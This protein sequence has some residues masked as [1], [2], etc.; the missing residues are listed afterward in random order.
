MTYPTPAKQAE[1]HFNTAR[2][3]KHN[4]R[5]GKKDT[6]GR[7]SAAYPVHPSVHPA[8]AHPNGHHLAMQH[9]PASPRRRVA[10]PR[11]PSPSYD[12]YYG[13]HGRGVRDGRGYNEYYD[14]HGRP[15][16]RYDYRN[17]PRH[18][19][20]EPHHM[21]GK[22]R[23]VSDAGLPPHHPIQAPLHPATTAGEHSDNNSLRAV[24]SS[25]SANDS[26]NHAI[27]Q[28][29]GIG[30]KESPGV[31]TAVDSLEAS[32]KTSDIPNPPSLSSKSTPTNA[33]QSALPANSPQSDNSWRQL[34]QIASI[35]TKDVLHESQSEEMAGVKPN[36]EVVVPTPRNKSPN[37][38]HGL[39]KSIS[40]TSSLSNSPTEE[41]LDKFPNDNIPVSN[42]EEMYERRE[43]YPPRE[44]AGLKQPPHPVSMQYA[45]QPP[46]IDENSPSASTISTKDTHGRG[47]F[48]MKPKHPVHLKSGREMASDEAD[49]KRRKVENPSKDEDSPAN[50]SDFGDIGAMPSWDRNWSVCS[51][52][53]GMDSFIQKDLAG[54][55]VLSAFSFSSEMSKKKNDSA[56]AVEQHH[57][58]GSPKSAK[59]K[60]KQGH[61]QFSQSFDGQPHPSASRKRMHGTMPPP[62]RYNRRPPEEYSPYPPS[63]HSA[64]MPP[65]PSH[66][67][68]YSPATRYRY[69][70]R[71]YEE[72]PYYDY[73]YPP[74]YYDYRGYRPPP[75]YAYRPP[76]E[77][78]YPPTQPRASSSA[79]R[80]PVPVH[81][82]AP[83]PRPAI[84]GSWEKDDDLALMEIMKKQKN[85]KNWDP[86]AQKLGR[87]K[88]GKECYDRWTRF[89]K[90]GSRKGQWTE[91]EDRIVF[92]AV[93]N[94]SEDPFTR[95]SDLAQ[96]LPG[97]VG[98]QVRD[99][100]VNHLN[101]NINHLPFSKEDDLKL[102]EG[103]CA[104]GKRWVEISAKHFNNTRS[105]NHI[106]NRWYS[107][108]F[109]KFI[110]AE[111]G[112]DAYRIGNEQGG[113]GVDLP[114]FV[115]GKVN[116][117][118]EST[119]DEAKKS[120]SSSGR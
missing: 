51:G 82:A 26:L 39:E 33:L 78:D 31:V 80:Q 117:S 113:T 28:N 86:I 94:S 30:V 49:P 37:D 77:Y 58:D 36:E 110:T 111:F 23:S 91:A 10:M 108:S 55:G 52:M 4:N 87:G 57:E 67:Y 7:P 70:P 66:G 29:G 32:N 48:G 19:Y 84:T 43:G 3:P 92:E 18:Y 27:Q 119:S 14:H 89:L 6:E 2:T 24:S 102:W 106:K 73:G 100:W 65:L 47:F 61:V 15:Y 12:Y 5:S 116:Y 9:D 60:R 35:D 41:D 81:S 38:G 74:R 85:V 112:P 50:A 69:P 71:E 83:V 11:P 96:Q 64:E 40:R 16:E 53:T 107:A 114:G 56:M 93:S 13:Y 8:Y 79:A 17:P 68:E 72:D 88:T 45:G 20:E 46:P 118:K 44:P 120:T 34:Q 59:G 62:G 103:H 54:N 25:F 63:A 98:K 90:P 75:Q 42:S 104:L 105:E 21:Y 115:Q 99:R 101:P 22:E 97:R 76:Q 95:W 109:K 1:K